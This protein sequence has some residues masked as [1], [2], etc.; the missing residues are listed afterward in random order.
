[1]TSRVRTVAFNGAEVV[2][3]VARVTFTSGLSDKGSSRTARAG[4]AA[5]G[6][7]WS[8]RHIIFNLAPADMVK[9]GTISIGDRAVLATKS[10]T[11]HGSVYRVRPQAQRF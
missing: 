8:P 4:P 10:Q 6:L 2:D 11:R 5:L 1:M 3:V 7:A 9:E